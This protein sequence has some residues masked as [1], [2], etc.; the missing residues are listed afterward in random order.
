M[1]CPPN[2][3]KINH[4]V[5]L[6]L[7]NRSFDHLLGSSLRPDQGGLVGTEKNLENPANL[8][9]AA[10]AV[11]RA[12]SYTMPFD[13]G[14]EFLDV[15]KQVFSP[16]VV[17][18]TATMGGFLS[19][20]LTP[21]K[22]SAPTLADA[23]R[24]ME[25]FQADQLP[26][27]STLAMQFAVANAW[28]SSLPGPTWPNRFFVHAATSGGLSDS[29]ADADVIRGY[30]FDRGTIYESLSV[31]GFDWRI[32]HD[33]LPQTAGIQNLRKEYLNPLTRNFREM[34]EFVGDVVSGR[35]PHYTFIEPD[36]DTG[37]NYSGGNSM[38]PLND[39]RRGEALLKTVYEQLRASSYWESLMLIVIFDEHGGFYDHRIPPEAE[40]T[41]DDYRYATL[42]RGFGFDRYGV[43]IPAIVISPYTAPN[44]VLDGLGGQDHFV[45]DHTS[46]LA[47]L[48]LRFDL[49]AIT[50][51]D[52][53]A[54]PLTGAL[55]LD[56]AR[57]D[58][59]PRI[60]PVP[61]AD[62]AGIGAPIPPAAA[63]ASSLS[64]NQ[65]S[66]LALAT[67]CRLSLSDPSTHAE[68]WSQHTAVT[69]QA[70]AATYIAKLEEQVSNNRQ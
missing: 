7:E 38:H 58:D 45:F 22:G 3:G 33:G 70:A 54:N 21:P 32:Y 65:Q 17:G 31:A 8:A 5:V 59:A 55:N 57:D 15:Q 42:G 19:A 13:P 40:P 50:T 14:H 61:V 25:C 11:K 60:L 66:F 51:R 12:T 44:T 35:L 43:R 29:P 26:V 24:V 64:D 10:V 20:A 30:S 49:P 4:F 69:D 53:A 52:S 41:G 67:A 6:M 34:G 39:I 68:I 28:Y 37:N 16:N 56:E 18:G 2:L 27:L 9:S 62:N 36:Y 63:A 23:S 46:V 47:T 1:P 48:Q